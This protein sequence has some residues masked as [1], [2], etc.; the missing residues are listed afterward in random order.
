MR[1]VF[2]GAVDRVSGLE[3]KTEKKKKKPKYI[4]YLLTLLRRPLR[5]VSETGETAEVLC[6]LDSESTLGE[7]FKC[8][9]LVT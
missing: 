6:R 7:T 5:N 1:L 8:L 2:V 4:L 9:R 3:P